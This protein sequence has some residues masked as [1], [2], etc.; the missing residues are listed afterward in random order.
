MSDTTSADSTRK[1]NRR[2]FK[3][4][5]AISILVAGLAVFVGENYILALYEQIFGTMSGWLVE[6]KPIAL[7][8]LVSLLI[9]VT[10]SLIFRLIDVFIRTVWVAASSVIDLVHRRQDEKQTAYN[11]TATEREKG[12]HAQAM[13]TVI[14]ES[15]Y[16]HTWYRA[17][18][19][20]SFVL[21]LVSA[22]TTAWGFIQEMTDEHD[23]EVLWMLMIVMSYGI[24][25]GLWVAYGF[26]FDQ[27]RSAETRSQRLSA[28]TLGLIPL[29]AGLVISTVFSAVGMAGKTAQ[30]NH[31]INAATELSVA[32]TLVESRLS[33]EN[34]IGSALEFIIATAGANRDREDSGNAVCGKGQGD[35]YFYYDQI[36][37]D[38]QTAL[39]IIG[40]VETSNTLGVELANFRGQVSD[41]GLNF[42]MERSRLIGELKQL[43]SSVVNERDKTAEAVLDLLMSQIQ[44]AKQD[45][46]YEG[47]GKC[48]QDQ[49][50]KIKEDVA[51][52]EAGLQ[53]AID[54][55]DEITVQELDR[56]SE[57]YG[58]QFSSFN[59][60]TVPE[61][62]PRGKFWSLVE[63][64][65]EVPA[66]IALAV[67]LD[68]FSWL[69]GLM[70]LW[71]P[72]AE[73]GTRA[74]LRTVEL[75]KPN[76]L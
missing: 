44:R 53:Q 45:N 68:A 8:L 26:M 30:E 42:P 31:L 22:N 57:R 73:P 46:F 10:L 58:N 41:P 61:Y 14:V 33:A 16:V 6:Y 69:I 75:G 55:I 60:G 11:T 67:V 47:W 35:M 70:M 40:G 2:G 54:R 51:V 56:L 18:L 28:L 19:Y 48:Q 20:V 63:T 43:Q 4:N 5:L 38:A 74:R 64:W 50:P 23:P 1:I 52:I 49:I 37:T 65:T 24:S 29:L 15:T 39:R 13:R 72:L 17:A 59:A 36:A 9:G 76:D 62:V 66:Y 71:A 21:L 27:M 25:Y 34:R 32:H 3:L 12:A 7:L